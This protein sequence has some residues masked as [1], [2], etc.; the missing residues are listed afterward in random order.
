MKLGTGL[1]LIA[2]LGC[3]KLAQQDDQKPKLIGPVTLNWEENY[4]LSAQGAKGT[5]TFSATKDADKPPLRLRR[6]A[7]SWRSSAR[8]NPSGFSSVWPAGAPGARL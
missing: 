7:S 8:L 5:A 1:A 3:E 2:L 4:K 6:N